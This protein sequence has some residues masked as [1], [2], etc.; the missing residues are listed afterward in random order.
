[1]PRSEHEERFAIHVRAVGLS[2]G[3]VREY[4]FAPHRKWR[5]DFAWPEKKIAVEIEGGTWSA[6]R[7]TRGTGFAADC[8][9][10]NAAALHGWRV[11]RFTGEMVRAGGITEVYQI[12]GGV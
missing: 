3:M 9:K 2:R 12:L 6:G 1:M 5:F 7:H 10:Y 11:L 8:E 4:Q